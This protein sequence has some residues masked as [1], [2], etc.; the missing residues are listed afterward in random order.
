MKTPVREGQDLEVNF[1]RSENLAQAKGGFARVKAAQVVRIDRSDAI[2]SA[3]I[4]VGLSFDKQP[5]CVP[6]LV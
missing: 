6:E 2:T 1:P 4:K 3:T 5:E